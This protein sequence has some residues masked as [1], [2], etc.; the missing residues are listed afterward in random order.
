MRRLKMLPKRNRAQK[1]LCNLLLLILTVFV[2]AWMLRFPTLTKSGLLRRAEQQYFLE[3]SELL[4]TGDEFGPN[5]LYARNGELLMAVV[6]SKTMLGYQLNWSYLFEEIDGIYCDTND[7]NHVEFM[8]FGALENAARA[9][10]EVTLD[11]TVSGVNRLHETY[12]A[13]GVR[14]NPHYFRF[15]LE[16]HFT[17]DDESIAAIEERKIFADQT[18]PQ[19]QGAVL[20]LYDEAGGVTHEKRI[21]HFDIEVLGW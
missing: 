3:D 8:A 12:V 10:L 6:Y 5:T 21:E 15:T 20:R 4:F 14:I 16:E 7:F 18:A 13:E 2:A 11:I 9:E 19:C 1:I 17:E